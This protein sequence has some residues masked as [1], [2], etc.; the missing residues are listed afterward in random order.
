MQ[1]LGHTYTRKLFVVY[2][3]FKSNWTSSILSG[4]RVGLYFS[5]NKA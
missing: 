4:T 5:E 2:L 3:K 1:Y